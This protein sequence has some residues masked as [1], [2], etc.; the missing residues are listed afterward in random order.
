[1]NNYVG[2]ANGGT[3][4]RDGREEFFLGVRGKNVRGKCEGK[5]WGRQN[6][7]GKNGMSGEEYEGKT[8]WEGKLYERGKNL[9]ERGGGTYEKDS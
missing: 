8:V 2:R 9:Y 4:R 5:M 6:V 7:R 1:M 3:K